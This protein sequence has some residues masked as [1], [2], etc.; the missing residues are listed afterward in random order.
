MRITT[1]LIILFVLAN[2][3]KSQDI[4]NNYKNQ[5]GISSNINFLSYFQGETKTIFIEMPHE[6]VKVNLS[7]HVI[8]NYNLIIVYNRYI[9]RNFK[10]VTGIRYSEFII[11][12]Q[13][14]PLESYEK[15]KLITIT[16]PVFLREI[17][18][19]DFFVD[20]GTILDFDLKRSLHSFTEVQNGFGFAISVGKIFKIRR[21]SVEISPDLEIHS[22]IPFRS[23][24]YS[25][26]L[27]IAGIHL[28]LL[29]SLK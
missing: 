29:Y 8:S 2:K 20:L 27:V 3:L 15:E 6:R 21:V 22:V 26:K 19:R 9:S 1:F 10:L 4:T 11:H 24:L 14:K 12:D 25:Q 18:K 23:D 7:P 17:F 13:F 5:I 28:G 16:I